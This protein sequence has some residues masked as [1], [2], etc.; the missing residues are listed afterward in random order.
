MGERVFLYFLVSVFFLWEREM[1]MKM[2]SV[3]DNER[4]EGVQ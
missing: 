3:D 4:S 2:M 1:E